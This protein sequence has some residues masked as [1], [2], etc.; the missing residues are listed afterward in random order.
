MRPC[1]APNQRLVLGPRDAFSLTAWFSNKSVHD[2]ILMSTCTFF[3]HCLHRVGLGSRMF[4]ETAV[5]EGR[6]WPQ[7]WDSRQELGAYAATVKALRAHVP[8]RDGAWFPALDE[9][10]GHG[11]GSLED[12]ASS[13]SS[14]AAA[15]AASGSRNSGGGASSPLRE[16]WHVGQQEWMSSTGELLQPG[17]MTALVLGD[18]G[19]LCGLRSARE[20]ALAT[21]YFEEVA[22][23]TIRRRT[24]HSDESRAAGEA[25]AI[26]AE[27][28]AALESSG[29][30]NPSYY[31]GQ[32]GGVRSSESNGKVVLNVGD[33]QRRS[34]SGKSRSYPGNRR[35][36]HILV[37]RRKGTVS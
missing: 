2:I 18:G 15:A 34:S 12:G 16:E 24:G 36:E 17:G 5:P 8:G 3:L 9:S 28:G 21:G 32:G 27:E 6:N 13:S 1:Y 35:T 29:S 25:A 4:L 30:Y 14:S 23:A 31:A 20:A 26:E 10:G 37:L 19:G 33:V 22:S 11:S 7:E